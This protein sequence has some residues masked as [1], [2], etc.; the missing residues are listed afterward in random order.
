MAPDIRAPLMACP[1]GANGNCGI[2]HRIRHTNRPVGR[3][4]HCGSTVGISTRRPH[5]VYR[6]MCLTPLNTRRRFSP[7]QQ[8]ISIKRILVD[9]IKRLRVAASEAVFRVWTSDCSTANSLSGR[10]AGEQC[11]SINKLS[12]G[13]QK[14]FALDCVYINKART[15]SC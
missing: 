2:D 9:L 4:I 8:T 5:T 11:S 3:K 12:D 10:S 7:N 6:L 14:S 13:L 1:V 15:R